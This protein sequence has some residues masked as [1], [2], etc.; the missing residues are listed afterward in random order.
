M[1]IL[2]RFDEAVALTDQ[3]R[4][5]LPRGP[6]VYAGWIR[7]SKGL[8]NA[9]VS[10]PAPVL[11]YVGVATNLRTRFGNRRDMLDLR[12]HELLA[13]RG[14]LLW[15]WGARVPRLS[16]Q[17]SRWYP[18]GLDELALEQGAGWQEANLVWIWEPVPFIDGARKLE[19]RLISLGDPLLNVSGP[20][21]FP[22]PQLRRYRGFSQARARWLWHTSWAGALF[23][24]RAK[25]VEDELGYPIK[26]SH[27]KIQRDRPNDYRDFLR[28]CRQEAPDDVREAIEHTPARVAR[29]WWAAHAGR[30]DELVNSLA[31]A[32]EKHTDA[33]LG[34]PKDPARLRELLELSDRLR[35]R[36]YTA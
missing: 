30:R 26:G 12:L 11:V 35:L 7:S 2:E 32:S 4:I 28:G 13:A 21:R 8:R 10:G 1:S 34:L 25:F 20:P 18:Q 19:R 5:G 15:S 27:P 31:C 3:V 6:G 17:R 29:L 24:N 36:R 16:S 14:V 22:P 33:A 23:S 9:G